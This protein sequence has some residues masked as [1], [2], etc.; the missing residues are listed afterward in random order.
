MVDYR[1]CLI[2]KSSLDPH[3]PDMADSS[4][5]S[6]SYTA[7]DI[8]D[9]EN[10]AAVLDHHVKVD[11]TTVVQTAISLPCNRSSPLTPNRLPGIGVSRYTRLRG[12]SSAPLSM[13]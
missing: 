8:T 4:V 2:A 10:F 9:N 12:Q 13:M 3:S 1:G 6:A 11:M 7:V 5:I